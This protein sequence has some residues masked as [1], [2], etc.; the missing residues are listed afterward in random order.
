MNEVTIGDHAFFVPQERLAA[1]DAVALADPILNGDEYVLRPIRESGHNPQYFVDVGGN[2]GA[3][4]VAV[5]ELFPG[6]TVLWMEPYTTVAECYR[7]NVRHRQIN[8]IESSAAAVGPGDPKKVDF[9]CFPSNHGGS[10]RKNAWEPGYTDNPIR[11]EIEVPAERLS[12]L[13]ERHQFP[14]IDV[15]KVDCEGSESAVFK[16]LR[17]TGWLSKTRWVRFEWHGKENCMRCFK[18]LKESHTTHV[19]YHNGKVNGFGIGH[20]KTLA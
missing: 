18:L 4:S 1:E 16:D 5:S 11:N 8:S 7:E 2:C 9:V 3:F 14:L 17:E 10:Y 15:L 19:D 20:S 12:R 13:L 6:A